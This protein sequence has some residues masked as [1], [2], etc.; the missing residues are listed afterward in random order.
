MTRRKLSHDI[1]A[2][3]YLLLITGFDYYTFASVLSQKYHLSSLK[4]MTIF[5]FLFMSKVHDI[6]LLLLL[7]LCVI[8]HFYHDETSY[9]KKKNLVLVC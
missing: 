5:S 2:K 1:T 7:L 4:Q 9:K 8:K 3:I 6:W